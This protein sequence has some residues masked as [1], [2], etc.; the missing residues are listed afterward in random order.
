MHRPIMPNGYPTGR[1][2]AP[3]PA[4]A[5]LL[6][7]LTKAGLHFGVDDVERAEHARDWWP[8]LIVEVAHGHVEGWPSVVVYA[9]STADV[10]E[11]LRLAEEHQ[12]PVT[13]QGGRSGVVGGAVPSSGAIALDLTGLNSVTALDEVAHSVRVGTGVFGPDLESYLRPRGFSVGHFPQSFDISTVG[14]WI[15]A[16]GAGQYSNRYGA[17]EDMVRAMTVVLI[18]GRVINLGGHG[19]RQAVGPDLMQLFIGSEGTLGV[20]TEVTL[21]LHASPAYEERAAYL[22]ADFDDAMEACRRIV[23][24]DATPA[25]LR[26]YDHAESQRHFEL[27]GCA[28]IVLDEGVEEFVGARMSVVAREC[29]LARP[30][31]AEPVEHWMERRNDVS[32]LAPLWERGFVVDTIEVAGPWSILGTLRRRVSAT[33]MAL[34]G[35]ISVSLHQSHAYLDGACLYFTFAGRSQDNAALYRRA[36]DAAMNEVLDAG[37]AISHHHGVGRNRARFVGDALGE[38]VT[39]LEGVKALLD[40]SHLLNPGVLGLGGPSW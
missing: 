1:F 26:L 11:V 37:G 30:L 33:L 19:P 25:V 28:L 18:G 27:E 22:F 12:V 40:P 29:A 23:Q 8:R 39:V 17:I 21:L 32:A 6:H 24:G 14:G 20:I 38:A 34:D 2:D 9:T 36:W 4:N 35:M 13:A 3:A 5:T 7:D 16:R 10:R 31:G 15:A